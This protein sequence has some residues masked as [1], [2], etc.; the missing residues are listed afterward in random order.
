[1]TKEWMTVTQREIWKLR[2]RGR[3]KQSQRTGRGQQEIPS[4]FSRPFVLL[5]KL[6]YDNTPPPPPLFLSHATPPSLIRLPSLFL[7]TAVSRSAMMTR[8]K[9]I[10]QQMS[11]FL[12]SF[13]V[14]ESKT[15]L[16]R[17]TE[18][19]SYLMSSSRSHSVWCLKCSLV[20]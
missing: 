10:W 9:I 7:C 19:C 5:K 3:K 2:K 4:S 8:F 16:M 12:G 15:V 1:M 11:V 6:E 17:V 18:T 14:D 13:A 20:I